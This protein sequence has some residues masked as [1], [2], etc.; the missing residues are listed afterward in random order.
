MKFSPLNWLGIALIVNVLSFESCKKLE[1]KDYVVPN[2]YSGNPVPLKLQKVYGNLIPDGKTYRLSKAIHYKDKAVFAFLSD[3]DST[4]YE[5][6]VVG[7]LQQSLK[8]ILGFAYLHKREG[9]FVIHESQGILFAKT[10]EQF[11]AWNLDKLN[12]MYGLGSLLNTQ[13]STGDNSKFVVFSMNAK[14]EVFYFVETDP[15]NGQTLS[16]TR[17]PLRAIP[18]Q[19]Y[20]GHQLLPN[21]SLAYI[22]LENRVNGVPRISWYFNEFNAEEKFINLPLKANDIYP[23]V[24]G[25]A[26]NK[27]FVV[28]YNELLEVDLLQPSNIKVTKLS[29][30]NTSASADKKSLVKV[31]GNTLFIQMENGLLSID[32]TTG[33]SQVLPAPE[34]PLNSY[35]LDAFHRGYIFD[36][37]NQ[38]TTCYDLI[39]GK[40]LWSKNLIYAAGIIPSAT[41]I[42]WIAV[43]DKT[44]YTINGRSLIA[45]DIA[46]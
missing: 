15:L 43:V 17:M 40:K 7:V 32:A 13:I 12:V 42:P 2:E 9:A 28:N 37:T 38:V 5:S 41:K 3:K 23:L 30:N 14:K 29:V 33:K 27:L 8:P 16:E 46:P 21:G 4:F 24:G 45:F 36:S 1:E 25:I 31:N 26:N 6:R 18:A 34:F 39:S 20:I 35:Q 10:P 11:A 19:D 22:F 44:I